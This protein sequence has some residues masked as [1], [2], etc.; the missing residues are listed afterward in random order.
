MQLFSP[1]I[2]DVPA[3]VMDKDVIQRGLLQVH[4]DDL[5]ALF[6]ETIHDEG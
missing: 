4:T 3:G 1:G 2:S 6:L 5:D